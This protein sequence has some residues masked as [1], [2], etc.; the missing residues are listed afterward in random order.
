M[1][2]FEVEGRPYNTED[3]S[4]HQKNLLISLSTTKTLIL[5][6]TFKKD[7]FLATKKEVEANL[8]NE[9][10]SKVK[11]ISDNIPLPELRLANGKKLKFS[12]MS[13]ELIS[14][15]KNLSFLNEQISYYHNQLQVLDT[16]KIAYS[17]NFYETIKGAE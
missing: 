6:V 11:E 17:K 2:K 4:D 15:V 9:F 16:A 7:L 1:A 14:S 12:E 8:K 10:G 13:E 5:E 3:F